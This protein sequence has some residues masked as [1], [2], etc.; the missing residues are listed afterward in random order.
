MLEPLNTTS[1]SLDP[2]TR[3]YRVSFLIAIQKFVPSVLC[4][5]DII[6]RRRFSD[7]DLERV[8]S[9][10]A[11]HHRLHWWVLEIARA[12]MDLWERQPKMSRTTWKLPPVQMAAVREAK[13]FSFRHRGYQ[14]HID[15]H[16]LRVYAETVR[17]DFERT[18]ANHTTQNAKDEFLSKQSHQTVHK[19]QKRSRDGRDKHIEIGRAHV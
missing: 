3:E 2:I 9:N 7:P 17:E 4:D 8:L 13:P 12:T 11:Q 19:V 14:L 1:D 15:G 16:D 18:L 6:F 10:W 5:L